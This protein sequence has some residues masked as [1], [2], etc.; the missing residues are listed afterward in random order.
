M[1]FSRSHVIL[2]LIFVGWRCIHNAHS[3]QLNPNANSF[4]ANTYAYGISSH[5]KLL[6]SH[7]PADVSDREHSYSERV[8]DQLLSLL[9]IATTA[10]LVSILPVA[11]DTSDPPQ[12]QQPRITHKAYIDIKIANYTEESIGKNLAARGSGRLVFGLYGDIAP[13]SVQLFLDTAQSDGEERPSFINCQFS[14]ITS[15]GLLEIEKVR[16]INTVTIAGSDQLEYNGKLLST[17]QMIETNYVKHF[18]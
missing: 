5:F 3:F 17:E 16:G 6:D 18:K 9:K 2:L 8:Q 4:Q 12:P 15:D 14:R 1:V 13:K 11:A 7:H 10:S